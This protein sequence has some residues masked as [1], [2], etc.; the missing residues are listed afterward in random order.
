MKAIDW[1]RALTPE[2]GRDE[3]LA[4]VLRTFAYEDRAGALEWMRTQNPGPAL[5]AG[6]ARLAY[7]YAHADPQAALEMVLR[8]QDPEVFAN[9]RRTVTVAWR[10]L[11]EEQRDSLMAK[12]E[13]HAKTLP[14]LPNPAAGSPGSSG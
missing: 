8:I 14:P 11:P 1:A 12:L 3:I 2:Q 5:D 7:E 6:T 10:D 4:E 13:E 9:I